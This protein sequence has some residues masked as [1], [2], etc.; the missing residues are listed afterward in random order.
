MGIFNKPKK[1]NKEQEIKE[2]KV[3]SRD[4]LSTFLVFGINTSTIVQY[5]NNQRTRVIKARV[6]KYGRKKDPV[7]AK[8]GNH[9]AFELKEEEKLTTEIIQAAVAEY[10][11]RSQIAKYENIYYLGRCK[12]SKYGHYFSEMSIDVE[13]IITNMI[14]EEEQ[15]KRQGFMPIS[16]I[17]PKENDYRT[18]LQV[19]N[20]M[21]TRKEKL[22]QKPI[23]NQPG[24]E[25]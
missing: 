25:R 21:P 14:K 24:L 12:Q 16:M 15:A 11:E 5:N 3:L 20:K 4:G 19:K 9:I 7:S 17:K 6:I 13:E 22:P 8:N 1:E 23:K 18:S 2:Y 10:E